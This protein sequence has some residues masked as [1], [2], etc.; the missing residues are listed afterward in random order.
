MK[1]P[2]CHSELL[3]NQTVTIKRLINGSPIYFENVPA[4]ICSN[5]FCKEEILHG[6]TV[7]QL[8]SIINKLISEK[9]EIEDTIDFNQ[10]D[11]IIS[12]TYQHAK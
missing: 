3:D 6:S 7:K 10:G 8:R 11:N 9:G 1:C 5:S 2:L 12:Q 4:Q